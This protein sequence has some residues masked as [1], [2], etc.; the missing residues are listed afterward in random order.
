MRRASKPQLVLARHVRLAVLALALG[1]SLELQELVIWDEATLLH[2]P[3]RCA[4][5][6][7]RALHEIWLDRRRQNRCNLR[8]RQ[9]VCRRVDVGVGLEAT[10]DTERTH[11]IPD[12]AVVR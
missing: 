10:H 2:N 4:V 8:L 12:C 5:R 11:A 6:E 3:E 7:I 9:Y 1:L